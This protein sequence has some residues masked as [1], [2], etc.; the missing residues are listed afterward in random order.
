MPYKR[1]EFNFFWKHDLD[2]NFFPKNL[3][4][5][6]SVSREQLLEKIA[7]F[8]ENTKQTGFIGEKL[9]PKH[10]FSLS[11]SL[12]WKHECFF[13]TKN[14]GDSFWHPFFFRKPLKIPQSTLAHI[15]QPDKC[16]TNVWQ[17]SDICHDWGGG[18]EDAQ[19]NNCSNF[20]FGP[21]VTENLKAKYQKCLWF[22][23]FNS[24][25]WNKIHLY[26]IIWDTATQLL[27]RW[28]PTVGHQ[29]NSKVP[30]NNTNVNKCHNCQKIS[31]SFQ[32]RLIPVNWRWERPMLSAA[33]WRTMSIHKIKKFE[34]YFN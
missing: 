7:G 29:L 26:N 13:W 6:G 30:S 2:F 14:R 16:L 21:N 8:G 19:I 22:L 17:L 10:V 11:L 27:C 24:L 9:C 3:S 28:L 31:D 32:K 1:G 34:N 4:I 5:F 33:M 25:M 15:C 20:G 18:T 23:L 12:I